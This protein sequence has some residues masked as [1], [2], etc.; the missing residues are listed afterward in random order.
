MSTIFWVSSEETKE[1]FI[2]WLIASNGAKWG[3][4]TKAQKHNEWLS[5]MHLRE[6]LNKKT[7]VSPFK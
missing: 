2:K 6:A 3:G 5:S 7:W 4:L 1:V